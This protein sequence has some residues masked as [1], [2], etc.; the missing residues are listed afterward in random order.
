MGDFYALLGVEKSATPEE[1]KRAYK[2]LALKL[3]P[4][5][6]GGD[7]DKFRAVGEAYEVLSDPEKRK[8]YDQ[9]GKDGVEGGP[10]IFTHM[11][12]MQVFREFF[13]QQPGPRRQVHRPHDVH[14]ELKLTFKE[15]MEGCKKKLAIRRR[16]FC[17]LCKGRGIEDTD[18]DITCIQCK[19]SG[20]QVMVQQSFLGPQRQESFCSFCKGEGIKT[21][22]TCKKCPTCEGKRTIKERSIFEVDIPP[23]IPDQHQLICKGQGEDTIL[24]SEGRGDVL[25]KLST[26]LPLGW[27]RHEQHLIVE[28]PVTLAQCLKGIDTQI[29]HPDGTIMH[30]C[31]AEVV[32]PVFMSTDKLLAPWVV[33]DK[34]IP[35]FQQ[36]GQ[37]HCIIIFDIEFP[38]TRD[39]FQYA[40]KYTLGSGCPC[41]PA[42]KQE[43]QWIQSL[44]QP[45]QAPPTFFQFFQ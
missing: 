13:G 41:R 27:K 36:R 5:R 3:H 7:T 28:V 15:V 40:R 19:G 8:R 11:D 12:P 2:K 33:P 32:K 43:L 20:K 22:V 21:P 25:L 37:G 39:D 6:P 45:E 18:I 35:S 9:Y 30:V 34:G 14:F 4:D 26:T 31:I 1:I 29:E 24:A 16:V 38:K 23:G 10:D 44:Y 17:G 42:E